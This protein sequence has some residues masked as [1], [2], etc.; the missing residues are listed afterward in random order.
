MK[1][2]LGKHASERTL[3]VKIWTFVREPSMLNDTRNICI[4]VA[5]K[6]GKW[7]TYVSL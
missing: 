7:G 6:G 4:N 5:V 3:V 2:A 1:G